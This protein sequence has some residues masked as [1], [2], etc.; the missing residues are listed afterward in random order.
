[1]NDDAKNAEE[2]EHENC[3]EEDDVPQKT[4]ANSVSKKRKRL[5]C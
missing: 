1:M 3:L 4:V 2:E 5:P